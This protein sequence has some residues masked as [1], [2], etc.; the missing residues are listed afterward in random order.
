MFKYL[1]LI[2]ALIIDIL[3]GDKNFPFFTVVVCAIFVIY[4]FA[5]PY[6]RSPW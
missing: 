5:K 2:V 1:F 3:F 6:F 4:E